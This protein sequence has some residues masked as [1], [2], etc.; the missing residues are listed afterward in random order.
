ML[1][2]TPLQL[3]NLNIPTF[4]QLKSNI[5]NVWNIYKYFYHVIKTSIKKSP[6]II[7]YN[8]YNVVLYDTIYML[9]NLL[10]DML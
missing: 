9:Y 6:Y 1:T 2:R 10:Y 3:K 8:D 4:L 5:Y 7:P